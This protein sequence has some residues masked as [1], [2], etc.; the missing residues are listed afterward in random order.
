[1]IVR[2]G[3]ARRKSREDAKFGVMETE[4]FSDSAGITQYGVYLQTLQPGRPMFRTTRRCSGK[5]R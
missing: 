1:M 3:Q 5:R 4:S 2:K